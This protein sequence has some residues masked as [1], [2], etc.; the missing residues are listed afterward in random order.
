MGVKKK[1]RIR[2]R[3]GP[4]FSKNPNPT[5]KIGGLPSLVFIYKSSFNLFKLYNA[6]MNL[7]IKYNKY[8]KFLLELLSCQVLSLFYF[9]ILLAAVWLAASSL[10]NYSYVWLGD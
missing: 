1:T 2:N 10:R 5:Q 6:I 7:R 8:E 9:Q 4:D 3:I